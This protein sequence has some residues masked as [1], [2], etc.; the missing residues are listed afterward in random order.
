MRKSLFAALVAA[1][2]YLPV[3]AQTEVEPFKPGSTIE[4]VTYYLPRTAFRVTIQAER[5]I[6]RPG[7]LCRYAERYLSMKD[8]PMLE[9]TQWKITEVKLEPFGVADPNKAYSIKLK[10]RT[11]APFVGLADDGV[12]L[13]IN[14][15]AEPYELP[16]LPKAV[17]AEPLPDPRKFLTKDMLSA[18][19]T[20]KMAELVA[21]EIYDIRE[22]R[23]ELI[24]GESDNLPKDGAQLKLML[25]RLDQQTSVLESFFAGTR[26]TSQEVF[27]MI[28]T[29]TEETDR[30][31][32][33]RFSE[34]L[35]IVGA[36]DLAGDPVYVSCRCTEKLAVANDEQAA[37]KKAKLQQGVYY[38]NPR[39]AKLTVF[40]PQ[41]EFTSV[42]QPMGQFGTVE[43]LSNT[44]FDKKTTTR[45]TFF[46][47]TGGTQDIYEKESANN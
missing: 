21:Q 43:I 44:L 27:S 10:G 23:D 37:K 33:F 4:G 8:V 47:Q 12:L 3:G 22:S 15:E 11:V 14:T 28:Y 36:D 6:I 29:P 32:L 17:P 20:S 7:E 5:T 24:R 18:G 35:G 39:R 9:T 26:Q 45:V 40:T 38:N 25:D 2:A 46:Q 13:S 1:L 16:E 41:Q 42:E 19:S 31:I 30:M 34:K